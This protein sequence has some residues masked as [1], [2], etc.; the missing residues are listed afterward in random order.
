MTNITI[1]DLKET[2]RLWCNDGIKKF[3]KDNLYYISSDILLNDLYYVEYD[4]K[5][6]KYDYK[7]IYNSL[8]KDGWKEEYPAGICIGDKEEIYLY[9]GC[10]RIQLN[11]NLDFIPFKFKYSKTKPLLKWEIS[12]NKTHKRLFTDKEQINYDFP[13]GISILLPKWKH[14]DGSM[15]TKYKKLLVRK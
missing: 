15:W 8:N 7:K 6:L 4:K 1:K 14:I 12:Q 9:D 3:S 11:I 10:H 5:V 2:S 13:N